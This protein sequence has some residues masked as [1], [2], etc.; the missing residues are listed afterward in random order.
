MSSQPFSPQD[1][2]PPLM[3]PALFDP[4]QAAR[5]VLDLQRAAL[6]TWLESCEQARDLGVQALT[7]SERTIASAQAAGAPR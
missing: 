3:D 4:W 6:D 1:L 5:V 7:W 2:L